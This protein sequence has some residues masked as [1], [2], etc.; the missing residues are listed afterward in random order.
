MAAEGGTWI[1]TETSACRFP[2]ERLRNRLRQLLG[3]IGGAMGEPIPFAC[4][5]W[6]GTKAA[7][8]FFSNERISEDQILAGHFAASRD[9]IAAASGPLLVAHDTTEFTYQRGSTEAIGM[10]YRVNSGRDKAGRMR[11]HTVCG[12]LMHSSLAL[13]AEGLPLGLAAVKGPPCA[14]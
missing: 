12:L 2:D 4:Q 9:R 10:T 8:R 7:Y 3:Q 13:T 1:E 6:A 11:Q 5:D 14:R